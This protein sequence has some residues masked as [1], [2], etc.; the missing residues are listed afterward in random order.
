MDLNEHFSKEYIQI[1]NKYMKRCLT[2]LLIREMQISITRYHFT[3]NRTVKT[4]RTVTRV[5]MDAEKLE[6]SYLDGRTV[7]WYSCF[8]KQFC[9]SLKC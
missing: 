2:S 4:E 6:P 7:K 9:R 8:R 1:A 3:P 5:S